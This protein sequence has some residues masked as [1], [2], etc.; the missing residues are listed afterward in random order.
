M[1]PAPHR[2]DEY[3]RV[4]EMVRE[5][6]AVAQNSALRER[7]RRID[8][9]NADAPVLLPV[10]LD[11]LGDDAALANAG[12]SGESDR[13]RV[14]CLLVDLRDYSSRLFVLALY[15]GDHTR[16]RP[17]VSREQPFYEIVVT[18]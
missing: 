18:H 1:P 15:L 10:E 17:P 8:G 2:A 13:K 6:Y 12:R 7:A 16:Q 11:E 5:P 9:D 3:A 4:E 14:A